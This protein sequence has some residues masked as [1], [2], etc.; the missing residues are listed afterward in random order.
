MIKNKTYTYLFPELANKIKIPE[1]YIKGVFLGIK[2][3]SRFLNGNIFVWVSSQTPTVNKNYV[4][5][6]TVGEERI[7]EYVHPNKDTYE[8]I[9][10][11]QYSEIDKS[12]KK[13]IINYHNCTS[14][15]KLYQ[16]LHK[17]PVL[18]KKMELEL[19]VDLKGYELGEKMNPNKEIFKQ[20]I[21]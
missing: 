4:Q 9:T 20:N 19:K 14:K 15:D 21:T 2:N 13:V 10:K 11:G 3:V 8:K 6:H 5:N 1:K 16:V 17:S 18:R 12:S 7:I